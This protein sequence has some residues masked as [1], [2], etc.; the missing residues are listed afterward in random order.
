MITFRSYGC[1]IFNVKTL[2]LA[3]SRD[4]NG[5]MIVRFL[6]KIFTVVNN[7]TPKWAKVFATVRLLR[8]K[9]ADKLFQEMSAPGRL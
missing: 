8:L 9:Y 4:F 5:Q 6:L 2:S 7:S 3:S 1:L